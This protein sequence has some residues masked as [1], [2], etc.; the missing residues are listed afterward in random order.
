MIPFGEVAGLRLARQLR[1]IQP[2]TSL[3]VASRSCDARGT[4]SLLTLSTQ[5]QMLL[6]LLFASM[7]VDFLKGTHRKLLLAF[8]PE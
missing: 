6:Q 8:R 7:T 2:S 3:V 4:L 1:V 5:L